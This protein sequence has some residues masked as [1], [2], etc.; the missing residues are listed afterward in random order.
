MV[1]DEM[2]CIREVGALP[3]GATLLSRRS[4]TA[5]E[6]RDIAKYGA[7]CVAQPLAASPE[8]CLLAVFWPSRKLVSEVTELARGRTMSTTYSL[9]SPILRTASVTPSITQSHLNQIT[10]HLTR[11]NES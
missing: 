8:S 4:G 1:L 9:W 3:G 7:V 2:D 5:E 10:S 6:R 11:V